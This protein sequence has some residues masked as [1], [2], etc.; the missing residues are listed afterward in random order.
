MIHATGKNKKDIYC[1]NRSMSSRL[2]I[3]ILSLTWH[4]GRQILTFVNEEKGGMQLYF[5]RTDQKNFEQR[6]MPFF[7]KVLS[8]SYSPDGSR[9]LLSAVINGMTDIYMH[10]IISGTNERITFDVADD[11]DPSFIKGSDETIIF[12]SNRL[13]DSLTNRGDPQETRRPHL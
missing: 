7:E 6:T 11:L 4:P 13:T 1:L 12:S 5:Y 8:L 10:T 2:I 9:L 3:P